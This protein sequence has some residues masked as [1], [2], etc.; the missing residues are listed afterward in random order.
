MA[1]YKETPRQ[2][3]IAMIYLVLTSLLALNVSKQMLDAFVVVNESMEITNKTFSD[4]I[5]QT[6]SKFQQQ[7]ALNP[8][9]VGFYYQKAE[10]VQRLSNAMV[11]YLDS[12]KY[13]VIMTTDA[14]TKT[15]ESARSTPLSKIKA[16]DRFTE[17]TRFFFGR[18][19]TGEQGTAGALKRK[20]S[21]FRQQMLG[22][23]DLPSDS[24]RLGLITE[25]DF[26]NA[27]GKKQTWEQH[28]FYYTVLAADVAILN[29]M[30]TEIK[31]AEF[32]VVSHLYSQITA[33]DFKFDKIAAKV[34]PKSNYILEG[35]KYEAEVIVAAYDT[36]GNP[37]VYY[38]EG[39]D[40]VRD[41]TNARKI[42]GQSGVVKLNFPATSAGIKKYAGIIRVV[43]PAGDIQSYSFKDEYIVAKPSLTVS[44]TKMNVLYTS[45]ENPMSISVPGM[46]S[47]KIQASMS[48][49]TLTQVPLESGYNYIARIPAGTSGKA[50]VT[51]KAEYEGTFRDM[52]TI[53]FRV[54]RVP[55]PVAYIANVRE[56]KVNKNSL[57][58][59]GGIIPRMPEDFDF[60]LN[61][62]IKSFSFVYQKGI[63]TQQLNGQGNLLSQEMKSIIQS[64][65]AGTRVWFENIIAQGPDGERRLASILL[66]LR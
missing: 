60:D 6:Y 20:I 35:D 58:A 33:E 46:S 44:A 23:M 37:E 30:V 12:L 28:L 49:G 16:K 65:S 19:T 18:S 62:I 47:E 45:V 56:G 21:A 50:V 25:G 51:V 31:N 9:K 2:K 41:I 29:K 10:E 55:D 14:R 63:E 61:Y 7:Y 26:R 66:E 15:L 38:L 43:S 34:I 40:T 53:E 36:K 48:V 17:P 4:K 59:A 1:G 11:N 13:T 24:D 54:K 27:D 57:I 3:M 22:Y 5:D 52:G 8:N 64:A 42:E 32:D 39:V